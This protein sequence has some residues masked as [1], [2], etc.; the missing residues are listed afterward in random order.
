VDLTQEKEELNPTESAHYTDLLHK[1]GVNHP[2]KVKLYKSDTN[3]PSVIGTNN[4]G[5]VIFL[6]RQMLEV[7]DP[8][9]ILEISTQT[10]DGK[11]L[12]FEGY[13]KDFSTE[14]R[15]QF[16]NQVMK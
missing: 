2:E 8:E 5:A 9:K 14:K 1:I 7:N 16:A 10:K 6:P 12:V 3:H 11:P 15:T 13:A 4:G